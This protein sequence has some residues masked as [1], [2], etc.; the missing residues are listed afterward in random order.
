MDPYGSIFAH[1]D[2]YGL[3]RVTR[4]SGFKSDRPESNHP[5]DAS[6]AVNSD[7]NMDSIWDHMDPYWAIWTHI[8]PYGPM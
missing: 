6:E 1:M 7:S 8:G 5:L 2:P 3:T 4:N